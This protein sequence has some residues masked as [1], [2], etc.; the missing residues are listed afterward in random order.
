LR[1]HFQ[2]LLHIVGAVALVGATATV[3]IVGF[4]GLAARFQA[5]R[6][7]LARVALGTTLLAGVPA[8]TLML[9]FGSWTKSREGL[10][11]TLDWIRIGSGVADGGILFLVAAAGVSFS[12]ARRPDGGRQPL[13]LGVLATAYLVA[14]A[15]AWWAM[16]AKV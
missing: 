11:D 2:L 13:I 10:P 15:V 5:G 6:N 7:R 8:W 1:P 12:W 16:T 4:A 3:G 9:V 14:L